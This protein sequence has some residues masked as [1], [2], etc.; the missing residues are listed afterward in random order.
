MIAATSQFYAEEYQAIF[1]QTPYTYGNVS[2]DK[3]KFL[4]DLNKDHTKTN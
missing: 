4:F 1:I 2:K 3:F